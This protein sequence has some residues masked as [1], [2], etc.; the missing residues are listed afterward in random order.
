MED[1]NNE[2]G[3]IQTAPQYDSYKFVPDKNITVYE[4]AQLFEVIGLQF[5]FGDRPI[6]EELKK[7]LKK[8]D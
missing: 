2:T 6:P 5:S 1:K 7:H 3:E 8:I 4:L